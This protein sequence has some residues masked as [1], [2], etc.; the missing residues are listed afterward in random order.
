MTA[1][2][3]SYS[4]VQPLLLGAGRKIV[5]E[6][7]T[8]SERNVLYAARDL[9]RFRKQFFADTVASGP[10]GGFLGILQQIQVV[11]NR[12]GNI[13]QLQQQVE[14]LRTVTSQR[15]EE[16][17][18][19]LPAL[20]P[21]LQ[22]PQQLAGQL[23]YDA[24]QQL[25]YWRGEMTVEQ[26]SILTEL[27]D[28]PAF[29]AAA[30]ELIQ[31]LR[32]ETVT[33]DVAQLETQ[34]AN[35]RNT[36]RQS[37]RQLQDALDQFKIQLGLPPD[38]QLN[39]DDSLLEQFTLIDERLFGIEDR[40]D[41]F[42]SVWA[43]LDEENPQIDQLRKV[44]TGLE[45]LQVSVQKNGMN[46]I[47][48]DFLK[49]RE[50]LPER[51]SRLKTEQERDNVRSN[52]QR[53][54]RLYSG[55]TKDFQTVADRLTKLSSSV[56][57]DTLSVEQRRESTRILAE[58]REDLLKIT[59]SLQ[60]IQAGLRAELISLQPFKMGL[61]EAVCNGLE[62]RLDLMNSRAFVMDARRREEI[63]ANQLLAVLDIVAQGDIRTRVDGKHPFDF[64][65]RRNSFRVGARFTAPLDQISERNSYRASLI[66]YQRSR[67]TYI[68]MEDQ[69]KFSIRQGWRQLH[70]LEEN[71]EITRQALRLSALQL[72][73]AVEDSSAPV[74][75]GQTRQSGLQG[76]NLLNALNDVLQA[77]NSLIGIWVAYETNRINIYR[78]MSIMEIDSK[79]VWSDLFY[80]QQDDDQPQDD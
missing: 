25:L 17:S 48:A 54:Q 69:V 46:L 44:V 73:S 76:R 49:V 11:A 75:P 2:V 15:P 59:K 66:D 21:G 64:R 68:S 36:L 10:G 18:E 3:L 37:E 56:K 47:E 20:P 27:S 8:Q 45:Q 35:S 30:I 55:I 79:G 41:Q 63:S 42:V 52:I 29:R 7:L 9:G 28:D 23:R 57:N 5:L 13:R 58:I 24:D 22:I 51:I 39:I 72:D 67:R 77:Q 12:R 6:D 38:F 71:F 43:Q 53:D 74:Q 4:L 78:D 14:L 33:L 60:V 65:G 31:R 26:E 70:V 16:I 40:V 62:N 1:S 32:I 19:N 50:H 61:Q 80:Q 34:L